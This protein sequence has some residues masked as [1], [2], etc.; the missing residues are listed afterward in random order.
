MIKKTV[1]FLVFVFWSLW[2]FVSQ[3]SWH[4]EAQRLLFFHQTRTLVAEG[5]VVIRSE[6]TTIICSRARYEMSQKRVVLWGPLKIFNADGDWLEGRFA[7]LDLETSQGEVDQGH[8]FL[9]K[10]RVHILAEKMEQTSSRS[11]RAEKAIITTCDVC[12]DRSCNPDW[13]F[14]CRKLRITPAG[15]AKAHH[16]TFNV[17]PVP[18]LYSPYVSLSVKKDR[19]SGFLFPR[20]VH[21]SREGFGIEVPFFWDINDSLDLTFYPYY[22]GKRG[23][24]SGIEGR[25]ALAEAQRG[26]V[27]ARYIKDKK[28][29]N[30]YNNDGLVRTN[31]K[32][33]W[34]TGKF[35]H[36]LAESW[37]A[38]LDLDI[39]SDRDFLYEFAGGP[40]GF[41][42]SHHTYLKNFG[43]GLDEINS[44][45]R[46]SMLWVNHPW[47]H[48]FFQA[49]AAYYDSQVKTQDETL[50]P[51][52]RLYFTRLTA[53]LIGPINFST[54]TEYV[55]WWRE[56]G[57]RG[58]RFELY[59]EISLNPVLWQPLDLRLA[60]R[61]RSTFYS[62]DWRDSRGNDTEIRKIHEIDLTGA[63]N[64]SRLFY[65]GH[66]NIYW[67]KHTLRPEIRYYYRSHEDQDDLP[68]FVLEDRL[69]SVN[70]IEYR[71]IQFL[72]A[73]EETQE[74]VRFFDLLRFWI[75]QSYD[76][77]NTSR[78]LESKEA[79]RRRWS[80]LFLEGEV[81]FLS[82]FYLRGSSS[83][84]FYGL[85]FVTANIT[86]DLRNNRG[87]YL[88]FD[89]R[90]DRARD[91]KQ[92]NFRARKNFYRGF[93]VSYE[94]EYS[95]AE[96]EL[97][98]STLGLT[99]EAKCWTGT[100]T[101][102]HNPDETRFSLYFNLL[103][104]GGF[105]R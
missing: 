54:R 83:Y 104:I 89:Y 70:R 15:R 78:R 45:Y 23:F 44:Y 66:K 2:P 35:D 100:F 5:Q 86:A 36:Q 21:G 63:L 87:E 57:Y 101:I 96:D 99:Y 4:I 69:E 103:G 26:V 43:R 51:L 79:Q 48:Y 11:Y 88:G 20:L 29:D 56:E 81:K 61:L 9:S 97:V 75:H 50:M 52:P 41:K 31:K 80:D 53:P 3:A 19:Q 92:L 7:W 17:K 49:E 13:S 98:S 67:L 46:R 40:L 38:H 76:F 12:A 28:D 105:G 93:F 37:E 16:V 62:V 68:K 39:L 95:F 82:N 47:S 34:I 32:R 24:M 71:L 8:L 27:R 91:V 55:Y 6:E 18:L 58:H 33:Y 30:D 85:G 74:G 42:S 25:Y 84:N 60:Y 22:T 77:K 64:F 90:W 72:T 102:Y 59:P 10:N 14:R 1:W 65:F 94:G 73:R